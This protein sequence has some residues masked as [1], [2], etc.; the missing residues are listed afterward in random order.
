MDDKTFAL[1][2]YF[3]KS[4]ADNRILVTTRHGSW[5]EL[6]KREYDLLQ[7]QNFEHDK[8]L[9]KKLKDIGIIL[10]E[11]N[12]ESVVK[13]TALMFDDYRQRNFTCVINL[14]NKCNLDC[15]YC[16]AESGPNQDEQDM[17]IENMYSLVKFINGSPWDSIDIEFQGGEST[18]RFDLIRKFVEIIE[19]NLDKHKEIRHFVLVT[20][21]TCFNKEIA[22]YIVKKN[23]RIG[24][25]LD[26][27]EK[28]HDFQRAFPDESGSYEKVVYWADYLKKRGVHIGFSSTITKKSLEFGARAIID[29]YMN[30]GMEYV[31]LRPFTSCGRGEDRTDLVMEPEDFF[32][33]W[34]DAVDYLV[35]LA[36][37]R[38]Y[39]SEKNLGQ[40][41]N[42]IFTP[43]RTY[44]C[45]KRPCGAAISQMSFMQDG[46]IYACDSGKRIEA[47]KIGNYVS[48][49]YADTLLN[50]LQLRTL[51]SEA[52]PLCDTCVYTAFCGTCIS[53]MF[54]S[55]SDS[56][57]RTPRDFDCK[58]HKW[59]FTYIF[60]KMNY[61]RYAK[62]FSRLA[63]AGRGD[64][65]P[66]RTHEVN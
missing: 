61:P 49:K 34:K 33:F 23:F 14:T 52:Q 2:E 60:K 27:P 51:S 29:E 3:T 43:Y 32:K 17:S 25:S 15:A 12:V 58:V 18:L 46:S 57:G 7:R 26:G 31:M 13:R 55:W 44:M 48:G 66:C 35:E 50:S 38:I 64:D 56:V 30:R 8:V 65:T 6:D 19:S 5:C 53:R 36:D 40:M 62:L 47:L 37:N 10:T 54:S 28:L 45:L 21:L 41:I 4:L 20:N 24:S 1:N 11:S 39:M 63:G 9:F 42:N 16:L 59:M 22:D